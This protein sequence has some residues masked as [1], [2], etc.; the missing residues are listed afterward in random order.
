MQRSRAMMLR[1][2]INDPCRQ[3]HLAGELNTVGHVADDYFR[4]L[5]R[6]E[7]VVRI[8]RQLIFNEMLRCGRF[9]DIVIQSTDTGEQA[10]AADHAARL[11]GKLSDGV[12]MLIS[13]RCPESKLPEYRQ[14]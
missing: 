3:S 11:F 5:R 12:G 2:E 13:P 4:A 14:V 1:D 10:I 8:L 7:P 6:F 9:A